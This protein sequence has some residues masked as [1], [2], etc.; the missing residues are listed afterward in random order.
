MT[1]K[2]DS[3]FIEQIAITNRDGETQEISA[4]VVSMKYYESILS[5]SIAFELLVTDSSG[6]LYNLINV[7]DKV[8]LLVGTGKAAMEFNDDNNNSL[9]VRS[10]SSSTPGSTKDVFV[11]TLTSLESLINETSRIVDRYSGKISGIVNKILVENLKISSERLRIDQT[12]NNYQFIGNARKPFN[13]ITWL[14]KKSI[15]D[16]GR[17]GREGSAGFFFYQDYDGYKF[18]SV[19]NI[20]SGSNQSKVVE[21]FQSEVSQSLSNINDNRI[22]NVVFEKNNDLIENLKVGMYSNISYYYNPYSQNSR[23]Y[24][25]N[26]SD[27]FDSSIKILEPG[28]ENKIPEG[29]DNSPSRIMVAVLDQGTLDRDGG[30]T[31]NLPQ[32][33]AFYQ[34]Q[35]VVRY[36]LIFSQT[37]SITVACNPTLRIGDRI[38]CTFLAG[39]EGE[40]DVRSGHYIVSELAHQFFDNSAYTGIKLIRDSYGG[41]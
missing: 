38:K 24:Q 1:I 12:I 6:G 22:L 17:E 8:Q 36:N 40:D 37:V 29:F 5:P 25:Y 39:R 23:S 31:Q 26:M 10:I 20:I 14:C 41:Q 34:S 11:L 15:T 35:S 13:I 21:Y 18:V 2:R 27:N 33:Q 28:S 19:D 9:Y 16:Y 32:D 7:G 4:A 3:Y 30:I